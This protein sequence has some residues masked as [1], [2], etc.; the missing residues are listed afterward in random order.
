MSL[1]YHLTCFFVIKRLTEASE[2]SAISSGKSFAADLY[3]KVLSA[4]L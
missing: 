3:S 4:H 2:S 1:P